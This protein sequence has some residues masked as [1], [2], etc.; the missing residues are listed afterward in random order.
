MILCINSSFLDQVQLLDQYCYMVATNRLFKMSLFTK[1]VKPTVIDE[2]PAEMICELFKYLHLKDLINCSMVSKR[3]HSFYTVFKPYKLVAIDRQ[4]YSIS[5]WCDSDWRTEDKELCQQEWFNGLAEQHLVSNLKHLVLINSNVTDFDPD[6]LNN[7]KNLVHLEIEISQIS[8]YEMNLNLPKLRVLAINWPNN[9]FLSVD[10]PALRTLIYSEKNHKDD[11]ELLDLK[12]PDTIKKLNTNMLGSK[13]ARFKNVECLITNEFKIISRDTLLLLPKLKELTYN[14]SVKNLI[15]NF[16]NEV[17]QL[18]EIKRRLRE[19]MNGVNKLSGSGFKFRFAGFQLTKKRLDE[20][21]FGLQERCVSH[22]WQIGCDEYVYMKNY[23]LLNP[24]DN[25]EFIYHLYYTL[26]TKNAPKKIPKC[27]SKKL[28]RIRWFTIQGPI[29]DER[30]LLCFL[31]ALSSLKKLILWPPQLPSQ[32]FF[33]LLPESNRSF[34]EFYSPSSYNPGY[35]LQLNFDFVGKLPL[36]STIQIDSSLSL[37]SLISLVGQF[38]NT[39]Y[40]T[41][42]FKQVDRFIIRKERGSKECTILDCAV[43]VVK[44]EKLEEIVAYFTRLQTL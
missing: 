31:K 4:F 43:P 18:K 44:T 5:K 9:M 11:D 40:F 8:R 28:T 13:L 16:Q 41:F 38:K 30:D 1:S 12:H 35:E 24:D 39:G 20:I 25:L 36:L 37:E 17:H 23:R 10:C 26:L 14:K 27:F 33:D 22:P 15:P 7:F 2:L 34:T 19:F 6:K 3:W 21:D 32:N 29:Q 42:K